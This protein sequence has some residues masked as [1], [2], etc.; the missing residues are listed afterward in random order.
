[1][2]Q[3]LIYLARG[4]TRL[5][6]QFALQDRSASVVGAQGP[7]TVAAE[8]VQAHQVAVGR[9]VQRIVPQQPL[10]VANGRTIVTLVLQQ[11]DQPFQRLE[12]RLAQ[13]LA[14]G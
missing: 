13:P 7:G 12:K 9:L 11:Q 6:S 5:H 1:M 8:G 10:G 2:Q 4:Q 3:A 14:F